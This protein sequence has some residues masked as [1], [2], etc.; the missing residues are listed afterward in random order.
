[1]RFNVTYLLNVINKKALISK[2][3]N[4][5]D[6]YRNFSISLNNH[7]TSIGIQVA[8]IDVFQGKNVYNLR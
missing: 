8:N 7:P 2:E 6:R 1:M 4:T 3:F 5:I